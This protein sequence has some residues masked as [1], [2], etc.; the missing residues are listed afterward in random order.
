MSGGLSEFVVAG[1]S[2]PVLRSMLV[3]LDV[4]DR[5]AETRLLLP[6]AEAAELFAVLAAVVDDDHVIES[7]LIN[8]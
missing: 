8:D 5:P 6:N 1:A 2:G 3:D 7:I 4:R